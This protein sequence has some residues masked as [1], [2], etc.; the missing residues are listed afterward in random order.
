MD[1]IYRYVVP[2]YLCL[3]ALVLTACASLIPTPEPEDPNEY[4]ENALNWIQTH[5]VF[6][7]EVNWK[8]IRRQALAYANNPRTTADTYPAIRYVLGH[9]FDDNSGFTEPHAITPDQDN[10]IGIRFYGPAHVVLYVDP[11]SPADKAGVRVGDIGV[12]YEDVPS[13]STVRLTV[14][15]VGQAETIHFVLD[16]ISPPENAYQPEPTGRKIY[17]NPDWVGYVELT[18]NSGSPTYPGTYPGRVHYLMQKLDRTPVCGWIIDLRRNDW[19]DIWSY[20][21]ALGPIMGE[22][23]VGGFL[24]PDNTRELWSYRDGKVFWA[25]NERYESMVEG[26]IYI[27]KRKMPP[28]ALLTSHATTAAGE[29]VIVA[30][31]GREKVHTFGENTRGL[32]MLIVQ[33]GLSDG[34]EIVLS[35]AY[36][37]DRKGNSYEGPIYPDE[38]IN[39]DWSQFGSDQDP[40]ILAALDWLNTQ[41]ECGN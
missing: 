40:V 1:M 22:G 39:T 26:G 14:Y 34:V 11:N 31:Q 8:V 12:S 24:Y 16:K 36:A 23:D 41:P 13:E 6:T 3:V 32:P 38:N 4:L 9:I 30:F 20:L 15:R 7:N 35:G 29:L 28:V 10:Y 21:A 25:Q 33:T 19:G 2:T 27:T 5:S 18:P 17:A 37:T